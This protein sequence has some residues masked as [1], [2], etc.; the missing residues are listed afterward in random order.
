MVLGVAIYALHAG[1][2][3]YD[4]LVENGS[5]NIANS[6]L[7]SNA[8]IVALIVVACITIAV[9]FFGPIPPSP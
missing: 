3:F 9:T 1:S 5:E 6:S 2:Q 4:L 7:L 8:G